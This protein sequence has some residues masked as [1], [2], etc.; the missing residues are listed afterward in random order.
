MEGENLP[1]CFRMRGFFLARLNDERYRLV[2][3][4]DT[5]SKTPIHACD[6]PAL[7]PASRPRHRPR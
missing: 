3:K 6:Q 1:C 5:W 2:F 7:T 4:S